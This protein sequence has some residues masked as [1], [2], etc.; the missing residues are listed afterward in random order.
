MGRLRV[1]SVVVVL[2]ALGA[3]MWVVARQGV[4]RADRPAV[5]AYRDEL[6]AQARLAASNVSAWQRESKAQLTGVQEALGVWSGSRA[7]A[8]GAR[9][10]LDRAAPAAANFDGGL[11]V[12]DTRGVVVATTS[13]VAALLGQAR[14]STAVTAALGGQFGAGDVAEDPLTHEINV[15]MAAPLRGPQQ[16]V[17]GALV[18]FTE[19]SVTEIGGVVVLVEGALGYPVDV[20]TPGGTIVAFSLRDP[21]QIRRVDDRIAP[22]VRAARDVRE[23][24]FIGYAGEAKLRTVAAFAPAADGWVVVLARPAAAIAV[25]GERATNA[26]AAALGAVIT[27]AFLTVLM[28]LALLRRR[29]RSV[30]ST[31]QAFLAIAGHELRTPLT[32]MKGFTDLLVDR[33]DDVPDESRHNIVETISYQVR[34]LEHLVERLLLG[35]QLEAGVSPSTTPD[36]VEIGPL[37]EAAASHQRAIAPTH[38]FRVEAEEGLRV[39]A[40][41]NAL[42]H[43][44]TNLVENAVKYSPDGGVVIIAAAGERERVRVTVEDEGIGLPGD[45]EVIFDKFVQREAVDTRVHDEGGVGLG[46]FI[47]RT[48]VEQ[49]GGSVR[50]ERRVPKG[51]R[52][53]MTLRRVK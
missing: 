24:G 42:E 18:G 28:L 39:R 6:I 34:N 8:A 29:T 11:A 30:E 25:S 19:V 44:I 47:V 46:L 37:L 12:V 40:D 4:E 22:A 53:V 52:F 3:A 38:E 50:A 20:V 13:N 43:V 51:A 41:E 23:P 26:A 33:W 49:M 1:A 7:Q 36:T 31:K 32:V 16:A 9:N 21:R 10:T 2:A 27:V 15:A 17:T 5:Q 45:L 48:L 35:A 14:G